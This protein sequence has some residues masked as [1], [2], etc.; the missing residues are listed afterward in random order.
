MKK[1]KNKLYL[2]DIEKKQGIELICDNGVWFA[3]SEKD[4]KRMLL[5]TDD[6]YH[7]VFSCGAYADDRR[8]RGYFNAVLK[9]SQAVDCLKSGYTLLDTHLN[10]YTYDPERGGIIRNGEASNALPFF[11]RYIIDIFSPKRVLKTETLPRT[12][13]KHREDYIYMPEMKVVHP[14][15]TDALRQVKRNIE[16][17][18]NK[19]TETP[20]GSMW[21]WI[22]PLAIGSVGITALTCLIGKLDNNHHQNKF[23]CHE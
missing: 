3:I 15:D 13:I 5:S 19:P 12:R 23:Y 20:S 21:E 6:I 22:I 4:G 1:K 18:Q 2:Y 17:T 10:R 16:K 11:G 14:F 7:L 9:Y 8:R